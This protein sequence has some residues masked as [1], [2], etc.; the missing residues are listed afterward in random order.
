MIMKLGEGIESGLHCTLLLAMVPSDAVLPA[1]ALAEFHGV[2]ES[3]LL[4][5]L[6]ALAASG[7]LDAVPGPKGG[8]RLAH[9]SQE[10]TVLKVVEAIEGTEPAFRCTEIRQRGPCSGKSSSY[11]IPCAINQTMLRAE[12]A[13][14]DS[15]N[16]VSIADLVQQIS[17][18]VDHKSV[19]CATQW[20]GERLRLQTVS[21]ET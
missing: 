10:I 6:Q 4:K 21:K 7:I 1:R 13:W 16:K 2:S 5:H 18:K 15:L 20:I 3:Y 19:Q 11:R 14:R 9:A 12:Q 8:Y 17:G